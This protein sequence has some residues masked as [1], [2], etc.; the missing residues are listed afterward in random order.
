MAARAYSKSPGPFCPR[1]RMMRNEIKVIY[2]ARRD[3]GKMYVD[4]T[5]PSMAQWDEIISEEALLFLFQQH[6]S[7]VSKKAGKPY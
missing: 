4:T 6:M 2:G 5:A 1:S 7:S 3:F